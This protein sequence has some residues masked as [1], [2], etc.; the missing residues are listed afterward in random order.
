MKKTNRVSQ[1][2]V[3]QLPWPVK[4]GAMEDVTPANIKQFFSVAPPTPASATAGEER[5]RTISRENKRWHTDK[6]MSR[7]GISALDGPCKN[8]LNITAKVVVE[9]RQE[10]QRSR[11]S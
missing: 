2:K 7:F 6:I 5:Y 11:R 8:A 9:L 1:I 3:E 4:S 10:A